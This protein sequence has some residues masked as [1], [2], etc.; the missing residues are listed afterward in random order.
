[1]NWYKMQKHALRRDRTDGVS[2]SIIDEEENY[3]DTV[4]RKIENIIEANKVNIFKYFKQKYPHGIYIGD[5]DFEDILI[6]L[7]PD[8]KNLATKFITDYKDLPCHP[9]VKALLLNSIL[10]IA[11]NA[12]GL[13]DLFGEID[14]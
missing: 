6:E 14:I 11:A 13:G 10:G 4:R 12:I 2:P 8:I 9:I 1:M 5:R 3:A 7:Q